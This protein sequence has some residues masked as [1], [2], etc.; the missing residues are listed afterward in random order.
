MFWSRVWFLLVAV[1]AV[2]AA[3]VVIAEPRLSQREVDDQVQARLEAADNAADHL[4][5][6]HARKWLDA[7][8]QVSTDAVLVEA[9]DQ[10]TRGQ[11][12]PTLLHPTIAERVK[13][14][15]TEWKAPIVIA[16]DARGRVMARAGE[17]LDEA[18]WKDDVS[19]LPIVVEA[20]RGYRLDDTWEL[21][22][23]LYRVCATP[24]ILS[25]HYAGALLVGQP[26]G[27]ELAELLRDTLGVEVAFIVR[28]HIAGRSKAL[29]LADELPRL[30]EQHVAAIGPDRRSEVLPVDRG[31]RR[32]GVVL[33]PFGGAASSRGA[34][35]AL[36]GERQGAISVEKVVRAL[37]S[38]EP[39]WRELGTVG[40]VLVGVLLI[41][42]LLMS[43]EH[44]RRV[45]K[46]ATDLAALER[47]DLETIREKRH[48][49]KFRVMAR[50]ANAL[51]AS[52]REAR[53]ALEKAPAKP[54][55][56]DFPSAGSGHAVSETTPLPP[57][58][59]PAPNP[60][61]AAPMFRRV[62]RDTSPD[63]APRMAMIDEGSVQ[64]SV[65][66]GLFAQ[67]AGDTTEKTFVAGTELPV[68]ETEQS[69]SE[70]EA[71]YA[72]FLRVKRRC[73]EPTAQLTLDRFV[74]KLKQNRALLMSRTLCRGVRFEIYVRE[75]KAAVRATP[76]R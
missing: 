55:A 52:L 30:V 38:I 54:R 28:G 58:L 44:G 41:G 10:S 45:S 43:A 21:G 42:F 47:G 72:E 4:L 32:Y 75:G 65:P 40:G 37:R 67:R 56:I 12:D 11:S 17:A 27:D 66:A 39:T 57:P 18:A 31:E 70:Y 26:M 36:I 68:D 46:L 50:A 59:P 19:S 13:Y 1:A 2:A 23:V 14:F 15:A 29:P 6:L 62:E 60:E 61:D 22:G 34:V 53:V 35:Y 7:V 5:R 63:A 33:A 25:D 8:T 64:I 20:L 49:G 71:V 48:G 51:A 74:H 9:L 24:L 16:I 3:A 76:I 73:G 69:E